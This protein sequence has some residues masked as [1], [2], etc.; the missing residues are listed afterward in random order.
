VAAGAEPAWHLYVV[1]HAEADALVARLGEQGV[2]AQGYYRT[3]V[4]RQPAM[5]RFGAGVSL[6]ES[7]ALAA[8]NLALPMSPALDADSCERVVAAVERALSK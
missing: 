7:D 8:T 1:T 2:G 5:A 4:H 3:P 6:P